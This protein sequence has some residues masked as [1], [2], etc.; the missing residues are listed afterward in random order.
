MR[1]KKDRR[2][3]SVRVFTLPRRFKN[4]I[5]TLTK[6]APSSWNSA[7]CLRSRG[8]S[9]SASPAAASL[10][11]S[12]PTAPPL[13]TASR[14]RRNV[15]EEEELG[16]ADSEPRSS[17]SSLSLASAIRPGSMPSQR[18]SRARG[19][20]SCLAARVPVSAEEDVVEGEVEVEDF[21]AT[22]PSRKPTPRTAAAGFAPPPS[23]S[24]SRQS[25]QSH[26][27]LRGR[28][29][30]IAGVEGAARMRAEGTD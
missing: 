4:I 21:F 9:A 12:V 22:I 5:N 24:P 19:G 25:R 1:E 16:E 18:R 13:A 27:S 3:F 6:C 17:P 10:R 26:G 20:G 11:A 14:C 2:L 30:G 7:A 8:S 15:H 28:G 29:R 23:P